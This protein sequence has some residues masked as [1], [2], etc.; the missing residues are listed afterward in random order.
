M[1]RTIA[2]LLAAVLVLTMA[3]ALTGCGSDEKKTDDKATEPATSQ[4]SV[5]GFSAADTIFYCRGI[6]VALD[7]KVDD[8]IVAMGE[9][10]SVK[11]ENSCH[12][13][14][15]DKTYTYADFIMKTY[16]KDGEDHIFDVIINNAGVP[17]SKGI[18]VGSTLDAVTA[19]YGSDCN[20]IGSRR[21]YDAGDG[22]TLRFVIAD[23]K[24]TQIEYYFTVPVI[25]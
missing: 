17:T 14:G 15:E 10:D 20:T 22:K 8:V 6:A 16:P 5:A 2:L 18:E 7:A 13:V 3:L 4:Q 21:V 9:A 12:G 24:V 11:S 19:A 23:G 25:S 1:K